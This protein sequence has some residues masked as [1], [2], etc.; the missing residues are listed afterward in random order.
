MKTFI[1]TSSLLLGY[2][3]SGQAQ[4]TSTVNQN[5]TNQTAQVTQ[6]G[7]GQVSS[8]QQTGPANFA[9]TSQGA[10]GSL[11]TGPNSVSINQTDGSQNNR[12]ETKQSG[13]QNSSLINQ[14]GASSFSTLTT[15]TANQ[16]L[17]QQN[18]TYGVAEINQNGSSGNK[19]QVWQNGFGT[20]RGT[21][22][23]SD[24]SGNNVG[25]IY[26]GQSAAG[27]VAGNSAVINQNGDRFSNSLDNQ[28]TISQL[29]SNNQATVSQSFNSVGNKAELY[30]SGTIGGSTARV[31][32]TLGANYN[33]V[34]VQ[35]RGFGSHTADINQMGLGG[36]SE[37]NN[38]TVNQLLGYNNQATINQLGNGGQ[39]IYNKALIDQGGGINQA[40][41]NQT[42]SSIYNTATIQQSQVGGQATINQVGISSGNLATIKQSGADY[43]GNTAQ[44]TQTN[45]GSTIISAN[46][47]ATIEQDRGGSNWAEIVQGSLASS[48]QFNTVNLSQQGANN[49]ARLR[50]EGEHN[51]STIQQTGNANQLRGGDGS[52][53][54]YATQS[55][56]NNTLTLTQIGLA[57]GN[58]GN[59]ANVSQL[60]TG[61]LATISQ[62]LSRP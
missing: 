25:M 62:T 59:I 19:A 33:A 2:Y 22:N 51:V 5:G 35:Q 42:S 21:I 56:L 11:T 13:S 53:G 55:G 48:A 12:A 27:A 34:L 46:N 49:Q 39:T 52:V 44:I 29:R 7:A 16:A 26:Q 6:Q 28:A 60:G 61:N 45:T 32:Q 9:S 15:S 43:F 57:S 24:R 30:Q 10:I 4:N 1:L 50:Q 3:H 37:H 23:Q 8:V 36:V 20:N 40:T 58:G 41:I 54:S 31:N 18:G 38:A 14:R 17:T 47:V